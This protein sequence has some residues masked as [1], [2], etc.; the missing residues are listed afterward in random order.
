[1]ERHQIQILT[2][3]ISEKRNFI[4]ILSGPRQVGKT[5]MI[6]Q[7]LKNNP[8]P[9]SFH[10]ADNVESSSWL[11]QVWEAARQKMAINNHEEFILVIDEI[12][13][14]NNWSEIV[15]QQWDYDTFNQINLKVILLGSAQLL[16]NKGLTES[17]AGRFEIL[18]MGH[19]SYLEM[20]EAFGWNID[21]YIYFGGYPGSAHLIDDENR[22]KSYIKDAIIETTVSKD[23]LML[24]R[25]DKP[26]L[27]KRLFELGCSYSG[28]ILSLTKV[29]GQLQDAG[30]TTTLSNYIHLLSSAGLLEGLEKFSIAEFRKKASIPKFQVHNNALMSALDYTTFQECRNDGKKWGRY[31][32]SAIG[33]HLLNHSKSGN[34]KIF[35]WRESIHEVDFVLQMNR[36]ISALEVKSNF[37]NL[38][39][40]MDEFNKLFKPN[41]MLLI[42]N[43]GLPVEEFL[44]IN[45]E[46][47]V[48]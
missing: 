32:E 20:K 46:N 45:P 22:W 9:N 44:S 26:A 37:E 39:H 47:L 13:K 10:S 35:Y 17:L 43:N 38:N 36:K 8:T 19:W 3:R 21:Q 18:Y 4:Q 15:K 31:I 12:Q 6:G 16:I 48:Y 14:I 42:G 28:Q 24:S 5:T 27:L 33:Q 7:F 41:R 34:L 23:I 1:M 25:V 30:N 11:V 40:G 2:A 29:I